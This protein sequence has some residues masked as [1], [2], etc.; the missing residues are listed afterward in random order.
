VSPE[1]E[2][3]VLEY[4]KG[5]NVMW[6]SHTHPRN[7][8]F[9]SGEEGDI[10]VIKLNQKLGNPQKSSKIITGDGKVIPYDTKGVKK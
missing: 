8:P 9:P 7:T 10:G 1:L 2:A 5:A 4:P 3:N 6:I